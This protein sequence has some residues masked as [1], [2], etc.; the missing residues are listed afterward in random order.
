VFCM[1]RSLVPQD[2]LKLGLNGMSVIMDAED[3]L[4]CVG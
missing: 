3:G 2:S 1:G 4:M